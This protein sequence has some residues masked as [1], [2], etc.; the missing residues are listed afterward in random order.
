MTDDPAYNGF[1]GLGLLPE[2]PLLVQGR[3]CQLQGFLPRSQLSP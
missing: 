2:M 3:R 1:E